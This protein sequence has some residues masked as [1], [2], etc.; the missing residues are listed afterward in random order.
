M[1]AKSQRAKVLTV[2]LCPPL[3]HVYMHIYIS[4]WIF[5]YSQTVT[6]LLVI[7]SARLVVVGL[8]VIRWGNQQV[9]C[10]AWLVFG[11]TFFCC[12]FAYQWFCRDISR[13]QN[14]VLMVRKYICMCVQVCVSCFCGKCSY[15]FWCARK[16]IFK[17]NACGFY[18]K[19]Q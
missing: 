11:V 16:N 19:P 2:W 1:Q 7:F 3:L 15:L 10:R 9:Y 12:S 13:T 17:I 8:A 6:G 4:T 5:A 18:Y 14:H